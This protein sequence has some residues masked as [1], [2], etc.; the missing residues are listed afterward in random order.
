MNTWI[1]VGFVIYA[2]AIFLISWYNRTKNVRTQGYLGKREYKAFGLG[3][4]IASSWIGINT[5]II[6]GAFLAGFGFWTLLAL[7]LPMV[8]IAFM[9]SFIGRFFQLFKEKKFTTML[10]FVRYRTSNKVALIFS[11]AIVFFGMINIINGYLA[12][13]MVLNFITGISILT[14]V[15]F[16]AVFVMGYLIIGGFKAVIATDKIQY[17]S[18]AL[19]FILAFFS[20]FFID[21]S[22][23]SFTQTL[24]KPVPLSA[25]LF[26]IIY[27]LLAVIPENAF[28]QRMFAAKNKTELE[29]GFRFGAI[30]G[31]IPLILLTAITVIGIHNSKLDPS[32]AVITFFQTTF[33]GVLGL[34]SII[35]FLAVMMSSMDTIFFSITSIFLNDFVSN[36]PSPIKEK[37]AFII[38]TIIAIIGIKISPN[39]L[40]N[41]VLG[42]GIFMALTIPM[43][44][45]IFARKKVNKKILWG[46]I[47]GSIIGIIYAII[48]G[49]VGL[50]LTPIVVGFS[51][52]GLILGWIVHKTTRKK[53]V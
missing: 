17:V 14:G 36:K 7:A 34:L 13:A 20:I 15:I 19:I 37:I 29:K 9:P 44:Y 53:L 47:L 46:S 11:L 32:L 21:L 25:I 51:I 35:F 6:F 8:V 22:S 10:D 5:L 40:N 26:F 4:S 12:G 1:I 50:E 45:I 39:I 33:G 27:G 2:I 49:S 28:W 23:I 30:L 48:S 24:F 18:M 16:L 31:I 38:L 42:V 3:T 43:C 52:A 41:A